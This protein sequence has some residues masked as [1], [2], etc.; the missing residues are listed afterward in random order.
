MNVLV[1]GG[2]GQLGR[3]LALRGATCP[4]RE[5]LDVRDR[6]SVERALA[7]PYDVVINAAA[8]T[9]VDRAQT[10]RA[11][12]AAV[13]R[14][15][16]GILARACSERGIRVV[17]VSTDYVFDGRASRPYREDDP[18]SPL[19][20][21]GETKR[22]GEDLVREAGGVIVRTSWLF[23]DGGP[24]FVHA[25][26]RLA[27]E[28]SRLRVVGDQRGCPTY[29]G[30]LADALLALVAQPALA[31]TYHLCGD[32]PTT[33]F[34]FATAIVDEVRRQATVPC[35]GL[36]PITT[37]DY[38]T[39]AQRPA[40]SVLDTSRARSL[41]IAVASWRLGLPRVVADAIG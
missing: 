40:Y 37:A 3:S 32:E 7:Q 12:A 11:A 31:D 8:F 5:A 29:A 39:A 26:V 14:D 17:Y 1:A 38:P 10:E 20:V 33:W 23:G 34:G 19:Q 22:D 27:R 16:A 28:R 9:H 36:D 2:R 15:G 21:Y 25:I 24:S 18:R 30:D 6:A 41:G 4:G 13:N 35:Q